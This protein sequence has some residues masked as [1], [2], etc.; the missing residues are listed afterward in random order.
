LC[1]SL[2]GIPAQFLKP[3]RAAAKKKKKKRAYPR[4]KGTGGYRTR[5][6]RG[7]DVWEWG[8]AD[9]ST[10]S[11]PLSGHAKEPYSFSSG[12]GDPIIEEESTYGTTQSYLREGKNIASKSV[13]ACLKKKPWSTPETRGYGGG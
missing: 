3:G 7:S 10:S 2:G 5:R 13:S 8:D 6:A 11:S 12:N 9:T 4:S 1:I